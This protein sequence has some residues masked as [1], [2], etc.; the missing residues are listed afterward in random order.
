[1][2][3]IQQNPPELGGNHHWTRE[4]G[5]HSVDEQPE[6]TSAPEGGGNYVVNQLGEKVELNTGT[7]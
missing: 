3:P 5:Y 7:E 4:K 2:D 6:P 1:M